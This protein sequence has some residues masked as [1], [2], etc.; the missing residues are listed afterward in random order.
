MSKAPNVIVSNEYHK[1]PSLIATGVKEGMLTLESSLKKLVD[2]QV[3]EKRLAEALL[4]E[5]G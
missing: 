1:L 5:E 4:A 3:I 2:Q